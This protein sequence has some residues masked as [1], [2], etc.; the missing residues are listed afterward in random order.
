MIPHLLDVII[1]SYNATSTIKALQDQWFRIY[2]YPDTISFK[3]GK[4][5]VS[6]LEKKINDSAPLEQKVICR[7]RMNRFNMEIEQQWEQNQQ[8]ILEEEF[9]N[10]VNFFPEFREPKLERKWGIINS[11]Y[12]ESNEQN[13]ETDR[14]SEHKDDTKDDLEDLYCLN[15][16]QPTNQPRRLQGRTRCRTRKWRQQSRQHE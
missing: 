5:Q 2:G 4:V 9:I 8:Q 1:N 11:G 10:T 3:Q 7:S 16:R 14:S 6:K 15:D 12:S 13:P